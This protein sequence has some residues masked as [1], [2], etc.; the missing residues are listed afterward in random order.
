LEDRSV[1]ILAQAAAVTNTHT[2]SPLRL[3]TL[4][5]PPMSH[6]S[7]RSKA[8]VVHRCH[9]GSQVFINDRDLAAQFLSQLATA[10]TTMSPTASTTSTS[11]SAASPP[12]PSTPSTTEPDPSDA[13]PTSLPL[14]VTNTFNQYDLPVKNTFI[15]FEDDNIRAEHTASDPGPCSARSQSH[16]VSEHTLPMTKD[17]PAFYIGDSLRDVGTQT[18]ALPCPRKS[19]CN[20]RATQTLVP[21]DIT[22]ESSNPTASELESI[23]ALVSEMMTK[24]KELHNSVQSCRYELGSI[25]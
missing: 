5:P 19:R 7:P 20:G 8:L 18:C 6:A 24:Q 12:S 3:F 16:D 10:S 2:I 4:R 21:Y 9:D 13:L 15:H 11:R 25:G 1:A 22:T 14:M 17:L 23:H